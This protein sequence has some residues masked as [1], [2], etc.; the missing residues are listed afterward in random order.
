M[1]LILNQSE[2]FEYPVKFTTV[3]EKGKIQQQSFIG[4]FKRLPRE[5]LIDITLPSDGGD[6]P[7]TGGEK[8]E[9]DLD[10]LLEL[11]IG[12]KEVDLGADS[13]F[14]RDNLRVLLNA[15]PNISYVITGA[16]IEASNGGKK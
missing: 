11:M 15:I 5:K 10:Y 1:A 8:I 14:N 6:S 13:A 16:Y 9:A 2:T 4:I 12:W 3:N 7:R